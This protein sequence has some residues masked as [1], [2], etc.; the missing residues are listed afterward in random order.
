MDPTAY[1]Q[2]AETEDRHWWFRGRRAVVSRVISG[3]GLPEKAEIA[4]LGA[5]TGGN[6]AMLASFG[7]V[8]AMELDPT[9]RAMAQQKSGIEIMSGCLPHDIP[10]DAGRYD[11]VCLFDV[12]EHVEDDFGTLSAVKRLL[13]SGGKVILTVPA[14]QWLWSEHDALLHHK[15]RYS[16]RTLSAVIEKAGYKTRRMSY[17]N[18]TL[19]PVAA[20]VRLFDRLR[21]HRKSTGAMVPPAP[22]NAAMAAIME[23]ESRLQ[24]LRPLPYGLSLLAV[25]EMAETRH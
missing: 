4:E 7:A 24:Q 9:A 1:R 11:L 6:L 10:L 18:A 2:M 5:G 23:F 8:S 21:S 13:R 12:L 25:F 19:F 22:L 17:F 3:L 15:R 20:A 14:H 16:R